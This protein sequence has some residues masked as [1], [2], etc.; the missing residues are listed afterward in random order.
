MAVSETYKSKASAQHAIDVV[1]R[2][3]ADATDGT[4]YDRTLP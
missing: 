1:K 4:N 2:E 3:A